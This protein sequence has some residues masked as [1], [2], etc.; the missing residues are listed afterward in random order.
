MSQV[1]KTKSINYQSSIVKTRAISG[2]VKDR[3]RGF[4]AYEKRGCV[5]KTIKICN[6]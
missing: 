5:R 1:K 2:S 6:C 4:Y 3:L